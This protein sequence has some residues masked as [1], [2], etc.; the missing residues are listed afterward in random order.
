MDNVKVKIKCIICKKI[1]NP[2]K[3]NYGWHIDKKRGFEKCAY[4]NMP[5]RAD[6]NLNNFPPKLS[7]M[8]KIR[9]Q[10]NG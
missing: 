3:K 5:M 9:V 8:G 2:T 7:K 4:Q 6:I 1:F 10:Y